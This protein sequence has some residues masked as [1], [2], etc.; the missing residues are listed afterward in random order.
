[1]QCPFC[2]SDHQLSLQDENALAFAFYDKFPVTAFHTLVVP[3]RHVADYFE[4]TQAEVAAIHEL[5]QR[6]R[7]RLKAADATITGFNVG[8]NIGADA[9]QT[10]FHVHVH[11]IP[12]RNGDTQAPKGGVRGVIPGKQQY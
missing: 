2:N 1:M 11:L 8:V 4:L 9:G 10:V 6:Q 5:L 12:R 3:R 7:K